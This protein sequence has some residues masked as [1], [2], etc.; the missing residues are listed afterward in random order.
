MALCRSAT[1][2]RKCDM[3]HLYK[4]MPK[5]ERRVVKT[6]AYH[7]SNRGQAAYQVQYSVY[8][9]HCILVLCMQCGGK[10]QAPVL[11]PAYQQPAPVGVHE[12]RVS[13]L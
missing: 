1:S 4:E 11:L 5:K 10:D 13:S 7:C 6:R 9:V 3:L 12:L 8:C 2:E